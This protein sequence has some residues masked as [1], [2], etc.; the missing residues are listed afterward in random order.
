MTMTN[1]T[2]PG[3]HN[4][5]LHPARV[6]D[7]RIEG[8]LIED[9]HGSKPT[10]WQLAEHVAR[11]WRTEGDD[12]ARAMIKRLLASFASST[13]PQ[14]NAAAFRTELESRGLVQPISETA[15]KVFDK[16]KPSGAPN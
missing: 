15:R 12:A 7:P 6:R 8:L 3:P 14:F 4:H 1:A 16:L 13:P 9:G 11:I 2:T 5:H 10:E